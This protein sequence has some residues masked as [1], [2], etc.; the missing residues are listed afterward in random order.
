MFQS[1]AARLPKAPQ[2][3]RGSVVFFSAPQDARGSFVF[4]FNDSRTRGA[5]PSGPDPRLGA[6]LLV[7][8]DMGG[9]RSAHG[10]ACSSCDAT[11]MRRSSRP[12]AA[13]SCTPIG[14]P[15]PFQDSGSEIAGC[16]VTLN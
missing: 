10:R 14:I 7:Y 12:Y 4:F 8:A 11:R 16:P 5:I 3:A 9:R 1:R 6:G 2:G 15:S 13:A